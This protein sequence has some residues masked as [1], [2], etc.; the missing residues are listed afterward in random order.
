MA[1]DIEVI[2]ADGHI[3]ETDEQLKKYMEA[4]W[5]DRDGDP[6]SRLTT[7]TV[8]SAGH[9]GPR[10]PTPRRGSTPWTRAGSPPRTS[11][12][13][14]VSASAGSARLTFR[15]GPVQG[16]ERLRLRRV[17]EGQP[18]AQ[19]GGAGVLSG[20]ARGGQGA[21]PGGHGAQ[22]HRV[23]AAGYR[24]APA[25]GTQGLLAHLRG[26]GEAQLHGG[27][28]RHGSRAAGFRRG[29]FSTSSSRSTPCPTPSPR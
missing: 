5:V 2:D 17:P 26:G 25:A 23:D 15:R 18:P 8:P 13:P 20:R 6:V 22:S 3:T 10:R 9:W 27:R 28:A 16:L 29:R 14:A 11:I 7:G 12:R 4:P 24:A 21:A 19:G 1:R